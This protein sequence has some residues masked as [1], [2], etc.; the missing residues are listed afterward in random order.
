MR[1]E[2]RAAFAAALLLPWLAGC[3]ASNVVARADRTVVEDAL[4]TA[5]RAAQAGE[6][7]WCDAAD[8]PPCALEFVDLSDQRQDFR[9]DAKR[10]GVE[11]HIDNTPIYTQYLSPTQAVCPPEI[12][13]FPCA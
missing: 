4:P 1:S 10:G 13:H 9:R 3:Y 7:L 12:T 5:W 6:A 2:S 11:G 8:R